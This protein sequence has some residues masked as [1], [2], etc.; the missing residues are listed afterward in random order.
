MT[1]SLI[2]TLHVLE[3]KVCRRRRKAGVAGVYTRLS[4]NCLDPFNIDVDLKLMKMA[5]QSEGCL[6]S[7]DFVTSCD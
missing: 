1:P 2:V 7:S 6:V 5:V 4:R 3:R